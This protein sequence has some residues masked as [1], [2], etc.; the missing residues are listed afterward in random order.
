MLIWKSHICMRKAYYWLFIA[1]FKYFAGKCILKNH[2]RFY[3][4]M[5]AVA[6]VV[7]PRAVDRT[8]RS[9]AT[10]QR[11][12]ARKPTTLPGMGPRS[13]GLSRW[14][15]PQYLK[16]WNILSDTKVSWESKTLR[17]GLTPAR[18]EE[19]LAMHVENLKID[20]LANSSEV[21]GSREN[22]RLRPSRFFHVQNSWL[23]GDK[24]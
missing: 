3:L 16:P 8:A 6:C 14:W 7:R 12:T 23:N 24:A 5:C 13:H 21:K 2:S 15:R 22:R 19:R 4:K 11:G 10:A 18:E 17:N 9:T 20:S 1:G